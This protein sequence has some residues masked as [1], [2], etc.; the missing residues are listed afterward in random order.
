MTHLENGRI[1][2]AIVV[3]ED[4]VFNGMAT[5][6]ITVEAGG[7]LVLGGTASAGLHVRPGGR[8][9]IAGVLRGTLRCEGTAELLGVM[10]GPIVIEPGGTVVAAEGAH[11]HDARGRS[12]VMGSAGAWEPVGNR[13][14]SIDQ[15]TRRWPVSSD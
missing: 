3:T 6:P 10:E 5:G 12:L 2:N 8:A 9:T 7:V 15:A 13:A 11:R 1:D 14:Y 4:L